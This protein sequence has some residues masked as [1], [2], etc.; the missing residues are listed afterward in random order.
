MDK[1]EA[2]VV[3]RPDLSTENLNEYVEKIKVIIENFGGSVERIERWDKRKLAYEI[4]K[5]NEGYYVFYYFESKKSLPKELEANLKINENIIR[6]LIL[7]H[8]NVK[9]ADKSEN[10]NDSSNDN[11][12]VSINDDSKD[13]KDDEKIVVE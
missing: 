4:N 6:Y 8:R 2:A 5:F 10:K 12:D 1:Y 9:K 11:S 3:F 13:F 7:L